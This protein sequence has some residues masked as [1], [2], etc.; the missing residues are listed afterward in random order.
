MTSLQA[1]LFVQYQDKQL[2]EQAQRAAYEYLD[3]R[4]ALPVFPDEHAR[5]E[6]KQ[7]DEALPSETGDGAAIIATLAELGNKTVVNQNTGRYFG[8][9]NGGMLPVSLAARWLAD[10][11]DQNAALDV[12]SPITAK[13]ET[14][15]QQWLVELFDLPAKSVAGLVGGTSIATLCGLAAARFRQ[16]SQLGW[17]IDEKGLFGAP[18]LTIVLGTQTHGTVIKALRLLGFGEAQYKWVDCDEQGR[19]KVDQLPSLGPECIL[20]LQAGNVNTGAFDDFSK[21]C[22]V[23]KKAGT[24]I[25]V[26]GA[27]GLW[28]AGSPEF[29]ALT[30]DINQADSWSVDAHKTLNTSYDCGIVLCADPEALTSAL[31]QQGSY[32]QYS[33]KRDGMIFTPDMSRRAR[34]IELWAS[35]KFLG[36]NGIAQLVDTMHYNAQHFAEQLIA[37]DFRVLNEV[38]FN[39][40]LVSCGDAQ[41]TTD[42]LVNIQASG[43]CWCGGSTWQGK[44]VIRISI[45]SWATTR[46]DVAE[47][48][49]QFVHARQQALQQIERCRAATD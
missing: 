30:K 18:E 9:V 36:R 33:D 13:L 41:L 23:A 6:L 40:V 48:V 43:S 34:G 44:P 27:F 39:Q 16:L 21:L 45:C 49:T 12:M 25:H 32:I 17:N 22:S 24:W 42:T 26:D 28:A 3:Q 7:L 35:L 4:D 29:N 38:V 19:M 37:Q 15:C 10:T 8:F 5:Q 31:H 20:V 11:W 2:F 46:R 47:S 14:L 1:R